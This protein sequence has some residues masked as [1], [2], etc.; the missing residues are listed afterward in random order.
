MEG[1]DALLQNKLA[2]QYLAGLGADLSAYG[3]N[4]DKGFQPANV[5]AVTNQSITAQNANNQQQ[6]LLQ[7]M[8]EA[9]NPATKST[10]SIGAGGVN[11][12]LSPESAMFKDLLGGKGT[13]AEDFYKGIG[14]FGPPPSP[15]PPVAPASDSQGG[16]TPNPFVSGQPSFSASDLAGLTPEIMA[17]NLSG[18]LNVVGTQNKLGLEREQLANKSN[19][20][21]FDALYKFSSLSSEDALRK[22]QILESQNKINNP[23]IDSGNTLFPISVPTIGA[24]TLDQWKALPIDQQNY[25]AYVDTAKRLGDKQIMTPQDFKQS[26]TNSEQ[27]GFLETLLKRPDLLS[28]K[29]ELLTSGATKI[30]LGEKLD[31]VKAKSRLSGQLYFDD[32]KWINDLEK[33][34][35]K[36]VADNLWNVKDPT[37]KTLETAKYKAKQIE[38]QILAGGGSSNAAWAADGKTMIWTVKWPSGD[39]KEIKVKLR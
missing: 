4:T 30:T 29:K 19:Q 5:N 11:M 2:M 34:T 16:T 35:E 38:A 18:A 9:F 12:K 23:K 14:A 17:N 3:A 7:W 13:N 21:L 8:A 32:P 31:E 28:L 6:K 15:P 37:A 1:L 33:T 10:M 26:F 20:E 24:V 22:Q 27:V 39:T 25:A 36:Y